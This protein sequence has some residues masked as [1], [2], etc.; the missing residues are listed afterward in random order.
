MRWTRRELLRVSTA[1]LTGDLTYAGETHPVW[2]SRPTVTVGP[3]DADITG[4]GDKAI[5]AAVDHMAAS[6]G[7]T[8]RLLPGA[9]HLRNAV[10]LRRG[11]RILG[12]GAESVL[13]KGPL[14]K[15]MLAE[16]AEPW[17]EEIV[18]AGTSDL[19]A[20]DGVAIRVD[21][22]SQ[23]G[24]RIV[25]RT[26]VARDGNRLKLDQA[27]DVARFT[28]RGNAHV[29]T[30]Y[31]LIRGIGASNASVEN[32]LLD[33][34]KQNNGTLD[35]YW[36]NHLGCVWLERSHH[37]ALKS[38]VARNCAS[39]GLSWQTSHDV[40]VEDCHCLDNAGFGMHA[41]SGSLR[42]LVRKNR[43]ERNYIGFYFCWGAR[44]GI[45]EHNTIT[46]SQ[47]SGVSIGQKD[48]D[49]LV[50]HNEIL[51]SGEAGVLFRSVERAL[52]PDRNRVE[53]NRIVD[54]GSENGVAID[55]QAGADGVVTGN[56]LLETRGA[57]RRI[58]L[59]IAAGIRSLNVAGNR[60]RGFATEIADSREQA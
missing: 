29:L 45:V 10:D 48:T 38:I 26:L 60:F 40:L 11:V 53:A 47:T 8:V 32:L 54:S 41:G 30:Q 39:D 5:Q 51:R 35:H 6:G 34:N 28:L 17:D 43:I 33:G 9:Y 12:S 25:L 4:T 20:G 7:G 3:K 55:V 27:L 42:P 24:R 52:W 56:E 58:G 21:D 46:D 57:M 19:R 59:K 49:N 16:D 13:R 2:T 15:A 1:L 37:V 36:G 44:H 14:A 23:G 50:H 31:P 22:P 18:L